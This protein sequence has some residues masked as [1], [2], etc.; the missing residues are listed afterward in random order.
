MIMCIF[1]T[2]ENIRTVY[3]VQLH[4]I[5]CLPSFSL[6]LYI[7]IYIYIE[8]LHS[9]R[10]G[11]NEFGLLGSLE[12]FHSEG[13]FRYP[14]SSPKS[15]PTNKPT[16]TNSQFVWVWQLQPWKLTWIPGYP[17]WCFVKGISFQ[18]WHILVSILIFGVVEACDLVQCTATPIYMYSKRHSSLECQGGP[19]HLSNSLKQITGSW[20]I[21]S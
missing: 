16:E 1:D 11:E 3:T 10:C 15:L 9:S 7:Y 18:I 5:P 6:S 19:I 8:L 17:K 12:T 14:T 20:H 2:F 4:G 21:T 13:I